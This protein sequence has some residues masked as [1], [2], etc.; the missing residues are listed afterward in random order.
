MIHQRRLHICIVVS[1]AP[2]LI[3]FRGP[4]IR[5]AIQQGHKVTACAPDFDP[6]TLR[7]VKAMG[8]EGVEIVLSRRGLNPIADLRCKLQMQQLFRKI[9]PDVVLSFTIKPNIWASLAAAAEGLPS[10]SCVTGLGYAFSKEPGRSLAAKLAQRVARRLYKAA[11]RNNSLVIFQNPDDRDDFVD[12][13]CLPNLKKT[14]LVNGSGVDLSHYAA[15]PLPAE[16]IFL[17]ISRLLGEKGVREYAQA[18]IG[19]KAKMPW[20]RFLLVGYMDPGLDG[21]SQVE[22]DSWTASGVEFVGPQ[23]D[24]RP[25]IADSSIYVLPSYREGTPRS[26]LE[27]MAMGRPVITTD[28]PG[29]RETVEDEVNG[30]LVPVRD[31][32]TLE[33]R[34]TR[35]AQNSALRQ[36]MGVAGLHRAQ[37]KYDV[38]RVNTVMLDLLRAGCIDV[39]SAA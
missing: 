27:A 34:M 13:G 21:V 29:C 25:W 1:F 26:V 31:I 30:Y 3:N 14:R 19:L 18:A 28:A 32:A 2:S 36:Q 38:N 8:A 12:A 15:V 6:E 17:M 39:L 10:V 23:S 24:V 5:A 11:A 4:L 7:A 22:L 16:P 9:Q 20:A 35:L 37:E 33:D